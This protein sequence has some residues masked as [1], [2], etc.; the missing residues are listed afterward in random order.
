VIISKLSIENFKGIRSPVEFDFS[1]ITLLFG[2]NSAGKS[3]VL[4]AFSY[5]NDVINHN[6]YDSDTTQMGVGSMNLGGYRQF[7]NNHDVSKNVYFKLELNLHDEDLTET[8][9]SSKYVDFYNSLEDE[10]QRALLVDMGEVSQKI[11]SASID[12]EIAW[13]E[14]AN[15]PYVKKLEFGA[16]GKKFATLMG[17][18]SRKGGVLTYLNL[19]HVIITDT[20]CISPQPYLTHLL[21]EYIDEQFLDELGRA[22]IGLIDTIDAM[23]LW[24]KDLKM[25]EIWA[26]PIHQR[27]K[28]ELLFNG[29]IQTVLFGILEVTGRELTQMKYIGPLRTVPERNF[30]CSKNSSQ[31]WADGM[32]AW[33]CITNNSADFV[34][35]VNHWLANPA[36]LNSGYEVVVEKSKTLGMNSKLMGLLEGAELNNNQAAIFGELEKLA[37]TERVVLRDIRRNIEVQLQDVGAGISQLIPV[38][39]GALEAK[40]STLLVEQPELHIHPKLQV[41]LAELFVKTSIDL[42]KHFILET[43]SEHLI[44]RFLKKIKNKEMNAR[45]VIVYYID[46]VNDETKVKKIRIDDDGKFLDRWPKGGFFPERSRELFDAFR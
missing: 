11:E 30:L 23:P 8:D 40:I 27:Q 18:Q 1:G 45:D 3:T 16:N 2:P 26:V 33:D 5:L 37:L 21:D 38:I 6:E 44:L 19:E 20:S 35:D 42:G 34:A 17:T 22:N 29:I 12:I 43:H 39:V 32:A 15:T 10:K 31:S 36:T 13:S 14:Y 9:A 46:T 41:E 25:A 7:V 4:N 24:R 28:Q